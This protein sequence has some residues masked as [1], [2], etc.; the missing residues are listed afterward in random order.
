MPEL[1]YEIK[2]VTE[3]I[4]G[5]PIC[6][7]N[8]MVFNGTEPVTNMVLFGCRDWAQAGEEARRLSSYLYFLGVN[9]WALRPRDDSDT[10][11]KQVERAFE[12][13]KEDVATKAYVDEA[14]RRTQTDY[15]VTSVGNIR[16]DRHPILMQAYEVIQAIEECGASVKLTDAVVKAGDLLDNL[17]LL[18]DEFDE[19]KFRM[20]G[21]EK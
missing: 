10:P 5:T 3:H 20:E 14:V 11:E 2:A 8:F 9:G 19:L 13:L 7:V 4:R 12:K 21:L 15:K 1:T 17:K 16:L 18:I 6:T